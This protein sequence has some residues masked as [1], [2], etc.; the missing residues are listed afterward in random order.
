MSI[1]V[2]G[3]IFRWSRDYISFVQFIERIPARNIP[4]FWEKILTGEEM[5]M[6]QDCKEKIAY[7]EVQSIFLKSATFKY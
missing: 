5:G 7:H 1:I 4:T 3:R 6:W 2:V